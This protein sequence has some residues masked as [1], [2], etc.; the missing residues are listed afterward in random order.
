MAR[1]RLEKLVNL[2]IIMTRSRMMVDTDRDAANIR[3]SAR[4]SCGRTRVPVRSMQSRRR[5]ILIFALLALSVSIAPVRAHYALTLQGGVGSH[6]S[7][8]L[9]RAQ[10]RI[11]LVSMRAGLVRYARVCN[12][13]VREAQ[14][15]FAR[16]PLVSTSRLLTPAY[17]GNTGYVSSSCLVHPLRC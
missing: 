14:F 12:R 13:S 15:C 2:T 8:F 6:S 16:R 5:R 1:D 17:R 3:L 7:S 10:Q 4:P 9:P 11:R